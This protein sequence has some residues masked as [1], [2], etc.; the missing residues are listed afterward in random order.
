MMSARL[1]LTYPTRFPPP[2]EIM[3]VYFQY[4]RWDGRQHV[5]DLD[6]EDILDQLSKEVIE[7]GD[8]SKAMRDLFRQG[9][10]TGH[11]ER[12]M[13]LKDLIERLR[14]Q[15]QQHL[16][17]HNLD[18]VMDELRQKVADIVEQERHGIAERLSKA[19]EQMQEA[20]QE[21]LDQ[22]K[23]LMDILKAQADR[24]KEA[25]DNLPQSTG[26]KIQE[27]SEYD[28]MDPTA[29]QNFQDLLDAIKKQLN[30]NYLQSMQQALQ[31]I[32]PQD[33]DAL[34]EMLKDLNQMLRDRT[35]GEDPEFE[36]FMN[37][38]GDMFGD[39][40]PSTL[41]QLL[42]NLQQSM[43]QAQSFVEGLSSEQREELQDTVESMFDEGTIAELA[44]L[45]NMMGQM[46]PPTDLNELQNFLGDDD[47][48]L[49]QA[50]KAM[51][52]LQSM[53][54]L[55]R[56]IQDVMRNGNIEDLDLEQIEGLI[57][58][59]ARRDLERLQQITRLLEEA[60]Y[61]RKSGT[62]LEL[63]PRGIRHLAQKALRE[64]F[65][66]LRKDRIGGHY[67]SQIGF[68]GDPSGDT[69]PYEFGDPF[70]LDLQKTLKNA[71]AR[72]GSQVPVALSTEDFEV[73]RTEH[74]TQ[75]ATVLL[76]DQSRSMGMYSNFASAKRVALALHALIQNQYS[77][78]K[79][80]IVGFSDYAVQLKTEDLPEATWN[81]WVSG[82]NMHH[83]FSLSRKLLSKERA[84]TKQILM[85]TDGEPTT[86][87][88]GTQA[89]FSYPP[90]YRTIDE[91]LKE[92]KRCTQSGI[93][94]NTFMLETSSYLLDFVDKMT[95]LNKGRAFYSS[96]DQLGQYVLVDYVHNQRR[97]IR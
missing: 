58:T 56:R 49:D 93:I 2:E 9:L 82:T 1:T 43:I 63:T 12:T 16:Q 62:K 25:L 71:V 40:P 79:L 37:K 94:I 46:V 13:G 92:V 39:N 96:A 52:Q 18:S 11:D 29:Q 7:Q 23:S 14:Q 45:A 27:L 44:Q 69:K 34:R 41:D 48:T 55:E 21:D 10:Q 26:G 17:R 20:S 67:V 66:Q 91:T 53:D 54:E 59:E 42:D 65:S 50:M 64:V 90:S 68:G 24:H 6:E 22:M 4:S 83:A 47:A 77:R 87:L 74:L 5:F 33:V 73:L 72:A 80:F 61:L 31:S 36:D 78:D 15:R 97:R 51:G 70:Q 75:T 88:E 28:F 84:G 89:Y 85:I 8:L 60:G 35:A 81:S 3:S 32:S 86:H 57:G 95:R 38:H 76:L 30:D 19:N